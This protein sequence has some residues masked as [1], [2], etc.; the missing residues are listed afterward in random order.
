M[1]QDL[2]E[3]EEQL[4]ARIFFCED[5]RTESLEACAGERIT[6]NQLY[7]ATAEVLGS[8]LE[9]DYRPARD[10][11]DQPEHNNGDEQQQRNGQR[12]AAG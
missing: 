2:G 6:V 11:V 7:R 3:F 9:P 12:R 5:A 1:E 10:G 8:S 4:N